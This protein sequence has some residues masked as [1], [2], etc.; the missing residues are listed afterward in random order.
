MYLVYLEAHLLHDFDAVLEGE[1]D[2]LLSGPEEVGLAVAVEVKAMDAAAA[3]AVFEHAFGPVA[4]G[5]DGHALTADGSLCGQLVHLGIAEL[6]CHVAVH[7]GIEDAGAVDAEENAKAGIGSGVVN[8]REGIHA[9]ERVIVHFVDNAV[10][11]AGSACGRGNFPG[12]ED[13][14]AEG[15]VGLVAGAVGYGDAFLEAQQAG[16]LFG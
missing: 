9:G 8:V 6:R 7:P 15:V 5:Q 12:I 16:S 2:A 13:V 10:H 14:Q 1:D 4:E 11:D 3:F